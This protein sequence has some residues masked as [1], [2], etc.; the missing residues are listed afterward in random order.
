MLSDISQSQKDKYCTVWFHLYEEPSVVKFIETES[1]I[2][3]ARGWKENGELVFNGDTIS[4]WKDE[5]LL[6]A[7]SGDGCITVWVYLMP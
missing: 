5:K 3:V 4:V 2:V 6:V 7:D 1:K